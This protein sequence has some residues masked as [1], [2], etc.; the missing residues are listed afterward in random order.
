M[1]TKNTS[2][3]NQN[4]STLQQLK[5][6]EALAFASRN[7]C[8]SFVLFWA[9]CDDL[10]LNRLKKYF[11]LPRVPSFRSLEIH[12]KWS[13]SRCMH[14]NCKYHPWELIFDMQMSM[15]GR[16]PGYLYSIQSVLGLFQVRLITH[17]LL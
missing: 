12:S 15:L 1:K 9:P 8:P 10:L 16:V 17:T 11:R 3:W 13:Y 4:I 7:S 5:R 14:I 6:V 2:C